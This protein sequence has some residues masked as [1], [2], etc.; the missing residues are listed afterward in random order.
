MSN[1]VTRVM[2]L[3]A[4]AGFGHRSTAL[5]VSEA[6]KIR[7]GDQVDPEIVNPLNSPQTPAFLR[8]SQNDYDFWVKQVPELYKFFYEASDVIIPTRVLE[9]ALAVLLYESIKECYTTYKPDAVLTTYP[10]YQAAIS[11]YYKMHRIHIPFYTVIT[12]LISVHRLW[13]HSKVDGCLVPTRI[14]AEM[15]LSNN[16]AADKVIITGI[17]VYPDIALETRPADALRAELGWQSDVTTVLAVGSRRMERLPEMLNVVNHFGG[18]LQLAVV[19]GKNEALFQQLKKE[20]WHIPVH[21]YDF[22]ENMPAL[23]K[24]SNLMITKA[25]GLI[26]TE[27]LA[28]GLPLLLTEVI[29]GQETGNAEYVKNA[30]AG[31]V[32]NSPIELLEALQHLLE[33]K[34]ALLQQV[35]A[36]ARRVGK[37]EAAFQV[38]EILWKAALAHAEHHPAHHTHH[39][40][41]VSESKL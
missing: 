21:S 26:V 29:P 5:A 14:V 7:Y 10:L 30:Q 20:H 2:I 12:D 18:S 37:P 27:S 9:D 6:L 23:M 15:A 41:P 25:G 32:I 34:G 40:R 28:C 3:T 39:S 24:A 17:P 8:D 1:N 36:N 11:R 19:A 16:V 33:N 22:V 4:D 13:F 38:A 35:A 31:F